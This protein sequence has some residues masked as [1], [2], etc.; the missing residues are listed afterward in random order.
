M[1]LLGLALLSFW[2]V[3]VEAETDGTCKTPVTLTVCVSPPRQSPQCVLCV[4]VVYEKFAEDPEFRA[5]NFAGNLKREISHAKLKCHETPPP[6]CISNWC[7]IFCAFLRGIFPMQNYPLPINRPKFRVV[8]EQERASTMGNNCW[9]CD[10]NHCLLECQVWGQ[11]CGALHAPYACV[12][13]DVL[14]GTHH[15]PRSGM[16]IHQRPN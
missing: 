11:L 10:L 6:P 1:E 15:G 12:F 2:A 3:I 16:Q 8:S 13:L 9:G 7:G 4:L 5:G 14:Q